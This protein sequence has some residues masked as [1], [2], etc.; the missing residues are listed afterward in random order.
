MLD[1]SCTFQAIIQVLKNDILPFITNDVAKEQAVALLSLLKNL[2]ANTIQNEEIFK[3]VN[4][5][6]LEQLEISLNQLNELTAGSFKADLV[7]F[8]ENLTSI[9]Q[10]SQ[11]ER[12]KWESVNQLFSEF[13]QFV[14]QNPELNYY[15]DDLRKIV[16]NQIDMELTI[17]H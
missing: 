9:L 4:C 15:I 17:V 6:L 1:K 7:K 14:Y 11:S 16:R 2:D 13:I 3:K 10:K 12:Y 5:H 8:Q